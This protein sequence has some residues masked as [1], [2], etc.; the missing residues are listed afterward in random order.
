[1]GLGCGNSVAFARQYLKNGAKILDLGCGAGMDLYLASPL[2][3]DEG[4]VC[5]IDLSLEMIN[6]GK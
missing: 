1:M 5:G 2:V 3:G 6:K 4:R